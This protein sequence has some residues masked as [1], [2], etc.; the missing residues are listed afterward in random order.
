MRIVA[1]L[2]L[3]PLWA[4]PAPAGAGDTALQRGE[5]LMHLG[6]CVSCHTED[7]GEPLAG[8]RKMATEFGY[9][10]TPNI[11]PDAATG[12]GG[13]SDAEF[14]AAMTRGI[15]PDGGHYYPS[16]P[17]T[18]YSGMTRGD[19][20]DLKQYLDSRPA[21]QRPNREHD[22]EFPYGF[23]ALLWLWKWLFFEPRMIEERPE[24]G[25]LWNRGN[26]IV[27]GPGHCVECHTPR[28]LFGALDADRHLQGNPQGPGGET[29]PPLSRDQDSEFADWSLDDILFSLQTGMLPDGDFVGGSMGLVVD[30]T[31]SR[32]SESDLRAIAT[33][34]AGDQATGSL[35]TGYSVTARR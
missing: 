31:T 33:Y 34:L 11:T 30:N 13:W 17:Y 5:Y 26:Y 9:F 16:F 24:N 15:A 18:S 35:R 6:G 20:L 28:N 7:G 25:P 2:L 1:L 21:I 29:V 27:N 3:C 10:Y 32:L 22:L 12:I 19:L 8:G 23:R 4:Q 14:I